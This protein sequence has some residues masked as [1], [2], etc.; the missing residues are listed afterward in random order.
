M[1]VGIMKL[2]VSINSTIRLPLCNHCQPLLIK[3]LTQKKICEIN[4]EGRCNLSCSL[5][6]HLC[7]LHGNLARVGELGKTVQVIDLAKILKEADSG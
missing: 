1:K 4:Q 6:N 2:A 5:D 7:K 3:L